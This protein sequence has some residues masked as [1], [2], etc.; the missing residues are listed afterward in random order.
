MRSFSFALILSFVFVML[1]CTR[2]KPPEVLGYTL[3]PKALPDQIKVLNADRSCRSDSEC[4]HVQIACACDCGEGLNREHAQKYKDLVEKMCQV[5]P[6]KVTCD[7]ACS[8]Q[9]K[10]LENL[11]TFVVQ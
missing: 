9:V 6:A 2:A 3:L 7:Q 10:C 4:V 5:N 8:G 1:S 11:C